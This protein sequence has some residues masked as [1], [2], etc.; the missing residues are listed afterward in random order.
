MNKDLLLWTRDNLMSCITGSHQEPV[1]T[2][3]K[4]E[5]IMLSLADMCAAFGRDT[6]ETP[7]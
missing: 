7:D 4:L 1:S 3:K 2:D 5:L 6:E